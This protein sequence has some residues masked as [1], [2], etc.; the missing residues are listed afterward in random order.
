MSNSETTI[1]FV[2]LGAMGFP[3]AAHLV[4]A[5][6]GVRVYNRTASVTERFLEENP[7]ATAASNPRE[8]CEGA[9]FAIL[10]VGNDASVRAV[11]L[12]PEGAF[13]GLREGAILIDHT[14][15]SATIANELAAAGSEKNIA[16]LDAPVSGG[17]AGAQNGVLTIMCGGDETTF[18]TAEPIIANYSK[19]RTLIG[20]TGSG[21]RAKMINQIA[22]AGLLQGLSE[23]LN[24]GM[25]SGLDMDKVLA[26]I[27]DG[28]AG[29]WQMSNR[30]STMVKGE[31]DF[32]F[33]LEWIIKDLDIALSE[34]EMV[35]APT[36]MTSQVFEFYKELAA[37]GDARSDTS[38]L[39]KRLQD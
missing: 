39:I 17:E 25:K 12:G 5:G 9:D 11:A 31:F 16:C 37:S 27:C 38:A 15:V 26:T 19:T 35:G 3:M 8:A 7:S 13:A 6:F 22:I 1:G 14:T 2:G 36:P 20:P 29:S 4:N 33:A 32:G 10:I 24:F 21:Q 18:A 30:G 34:A 23:A 28:A